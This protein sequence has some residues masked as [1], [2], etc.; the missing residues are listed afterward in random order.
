[1]NE[2][3]APLRPSPFRPLIVVFVLFAA[4]AAMTGISRWWIPAERVPWQSD[5][6]RAQQEAKIAGKPVLV[7]FTAD[8]CPPCQLLRRYVWSDVAV[9]RAMQSYVPVRIDIDKDPA[10]ALRY[11]ADQ[12]LPLLVVLDNEGNVVR[13]YDGG[14]EAAQ[15]VEWL[16][17][18]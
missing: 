4:V 16:N 14:P 17:G 7:Y 10:L 2:S 6:A 8:W 12:A 5:L 18:G 3:Q 13:T 11:G 9:E 15:M 1:M